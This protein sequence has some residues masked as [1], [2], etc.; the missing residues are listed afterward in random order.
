MVIMNTM[1][2]I[3]ITMMI[4]YI[5]MII[6]SQCSNRFVKKWKYH[7]R[8]CLLSFWNYNY[9]TLKEIQEHFSF[10]FSDLIF[11][12]LKKIHSFC[13]RNHLPPSFWIFREEN[14]IIQ[15]ELSVPSS[16]PGR[17]V[18]VTPQMLRWVFKPS[19]S[20]KRRACFSLF[21]IF[22]VACTTVFVVWYIVFFFSILPSPTEG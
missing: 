14:L 22:Q 6:I 13:N 4:I 19:G 10:Y 20:L 1:T 15:E 5:I 3:I 16:A 8:T 18:S 21:R 12:S 11:I 7:C 2:T 9:M 17:T